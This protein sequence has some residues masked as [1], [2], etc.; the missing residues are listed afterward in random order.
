MIVMTIVIDFNNYHDYHL[1]LAF[2]THEDTEAQ[3]SHICKG[4]LFHYSF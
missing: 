1:T 2:L 3:T 4:F